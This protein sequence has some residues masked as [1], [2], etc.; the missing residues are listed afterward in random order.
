MVFTVLARG[1][2]NGESQSGLGYLMVS[3]ATVDKVWS[4]V[5]LLLAL[6]APQRRVEKLLFSVA[7]LRTTKILSLR[8]MVRASDAGGLRAP[9]LRE[10]HTD[11]ACLFPP[12]TQLPNYD[13]QGERDP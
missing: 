12:M 6:S 4:L 1:F 13:P 2:G 7:A 9:E 8:V 5:L 10:I 11:R 3:V